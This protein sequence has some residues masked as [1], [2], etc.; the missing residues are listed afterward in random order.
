MG[1]VDKMAL[2]KGPNEIEKE[3]LRI[4]PVLDDGGFI[5][6]IDH[7]VPA[8]VSLENYRFYL[9]FKKEIFGIG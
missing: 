8:D 9:K 1:G 6:H 2:R 3:I 5:P 7:R 4:K